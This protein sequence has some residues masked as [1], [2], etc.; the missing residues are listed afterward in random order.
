MK[1]H[2]KTKYDFGLRVN[3]RY[4]NKGLTGVSKKEH[5]EIHG[6]NRPGMEI[7]NRRK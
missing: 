4:E 6:I 5:E 3:I 2:S 7:S 1:M